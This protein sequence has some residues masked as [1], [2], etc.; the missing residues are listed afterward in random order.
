MWGIQGRPVSAAPQ[1]FPEELRPTAVSFARLASGRRVLR[2]PS[3]VPMKI[4]EQR[5]AER[6]PFAC[7]IRAIEDRYLTGASAET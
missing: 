7:L 4:C 2:D 3:R 1:S 5:C 6:F